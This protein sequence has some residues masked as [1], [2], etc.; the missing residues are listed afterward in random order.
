[1]DRITRIRSEAVDLAH[2]LNVPFYLE[3]NCNYIIV[4]NFKLPEGFQ[5]KQTD[6]LLKL[7]D[8]PNIPPGLGR[9]K[10]YLAYNLRVHGRQLKFFHFDSDL[11]YKG[12]HHRCFTRIDWD[13]NIDTLV[14]FFDCLLFALQEDSLE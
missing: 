13:S 12:W 7:I 4:Y 9:N 3:C 14:T 6:V 10:V 2:F 11:S 5:L 8:Y 1:M